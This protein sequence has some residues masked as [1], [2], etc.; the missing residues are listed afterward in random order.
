MNIVAPLLNDLPCECCETKNLWHFYSFMF[1]SLFSCFILIY[2][3]RVK[4]IMENWN[5]SDSTCA[6]HIECYEMA[7][8]VIIIIS[9]IDSRNN[10]FYS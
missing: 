10:F 3:I 1:I 2:L 4:S 7:G 6:L 9:I 8:L 5:F